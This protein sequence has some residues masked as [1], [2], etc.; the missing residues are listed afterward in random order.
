[1]IFCEKLIFYRKIDFREL[2]LLLSWGSPP[3]LGGGGTLVT[4]PWYF[5]KMFLN[6]F[7]NIP[8][9][10]E[11]LLK[12]SGTFFGSQGPFKSHFLDF[13]EKLI[14][15]CIF[16]RGTTQDLHRNYT[17]IWYRL[18]QIPFLDKYSS[19]LVPNHHCSIKKRLYLLKPH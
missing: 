7:L 14:F 10:P 8:E 6:I 1:M 12:R 18:I 9:H 4:W 5:S 3:P 13:F 17:G 11:T 2:P 15:L 19:P 16:P